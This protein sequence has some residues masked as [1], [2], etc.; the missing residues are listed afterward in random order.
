MGGVVVG[1]RELEFN[2]GGWEGGAALDAAFEGVGEG[3]EGGCGGLE[4]GCFFGVGEVCAGGAVAVPVGVVLVWGEFVDEGGKRLPEVVVEVVSAG[5]VGFVGEHD[6][7]SAVVV[8]AG[9]VRDET[10][11]CW[12]VGHLRSLAW[13]GITIRVG[14]EDV[15]VALRRGA[16]PFKSVCRH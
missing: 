3:D 8:F 7:G 10:L 13:G 6:T 9:S 12:A 1:G 4:G 16:L 2:P 15:F 11:L 14:D 5:F